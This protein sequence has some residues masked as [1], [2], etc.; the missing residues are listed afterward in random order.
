MSSKKKKPGWIQSIKDFCSK[1]EKAIAAFAAVAGVAYGLGYKTASVFK[2]REIMAIENRHSAEL[3]NL[4]E[5]YM[6]KYFTLR[7]QQF[8]NDQKDSTDGNKNIQGNIK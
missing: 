6:D 1:Y 8:I 2:E 5:E 4:K 3:L 7:E